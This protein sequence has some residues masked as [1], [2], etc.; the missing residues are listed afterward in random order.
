M[1]PLRFKN[2]ELIRY[3]EESMRHRGV[4]TLNVGIFQN[5]EI[6]TAAFEQL[7]ALHAAVWSH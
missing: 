2:E 4:V 5:G 7:Q 3:V 1:E 6:G